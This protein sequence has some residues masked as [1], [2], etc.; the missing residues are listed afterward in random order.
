MFND[1]EYGRRNSAVVLVETAGYTMPL[2]DS[3]EPRLVYRERNLDT[4]FRAEVDC[5][6]VSGARGHHACR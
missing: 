1:F 6:R 5:A 4:R 2:P 3:V